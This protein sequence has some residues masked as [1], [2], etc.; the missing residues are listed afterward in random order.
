[1]ELDEAKKACKTTIDEL[2][3]IGVEAILFFTHPFYQ[4]YLDEDYIAEADT[5]FDHTN[6]TWTNIGNIA[7]IENELWQ[8]MWREKYIPG[9]VDV[10][11]SGVMIDEGAVQYMVCSRKDHSHGTNAISMLSSY[12]KGS[13]DLLQ[14]FWDG[15][16]DRSPLF[17]C[18]SGSDLLARTIELWGADSEIVRYTIPYRIQA[19]PGDWSGPRTVSEVN[20]SIVNGFLLGGYYGFD[21]D[22]WPSTLDDDVRRYVNMRRELRKMKA[23]GFPNGFRDTVGLKVGDSNLVAKAY[24][25]S[26]GITVIYYA[27]EDVETEVAVNKAILGFPEAKE[28]VFQ[29]N[30]KK[31]EAEYKIIRVYY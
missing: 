24:R 16:S 18:E 20:Y 27:K 13:L 29:V 28:E 31:D 21:L 14:A 23:P 6:V 2:R 22:K 12:V 17:F 25:N 8:K 5:G 10:G 4:H 30:L 7:C 19:G 3:K 9:Y 26:K 11:A 1:M 15:F